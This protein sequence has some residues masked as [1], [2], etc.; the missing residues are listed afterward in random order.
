[1]P[2]PT[3]PRSAD[4]TASL[5][6]EVR[7]RM[8]ETFLDEAST[9]VVELE[10]A[11]LRLERGGDSSAVDG[12]FRAAHTIKGS[13]ASVGFLAV[14]AFVHEV[15]FALE[16]LR[17]GRAELTPV[18]LEALLV[19]VDAAGTLLDA[20]AIGAEAPDVSEALTRLRRAF[21]GAN[22]MRTAVDHAAPKPVADAT[23]A[24]V[25]ALPAER[26]A[27]AAIALDDGLTL[28]HARF[29]LPPDAFER[30]LDPLVL[31]LALAEEGVMIHSEALL[32]GLP[33]LAALDPMRCHLGF[34]VL[35]ATADTEEARAALEFVPADAEVVIDVLDADAWHTLT[36]PAAAA[37]T[38]PT[39]RGDEPRAATVRGLRVRQERVDG[40]IEL[41]GELVTARN[42]LLH[43]QRQV[44]EG[45]DGAEVARRLK[46]TSGAINRMVGQ[47]QSDVLGLRMVPMRTAME[48]LPRVIRDVAA[49]R[50][51]L[52]ALAVIGDDTEV[53]RAVAD[54][55]ADPLVHLVRNAI[56]HGV[57]S[58]QARLAAGKAPE[59]RVTVTARREAHGVVVEVRDDGDGIDAARVRA[60]AVARGV[61]DQA[62]ADR[63]S[64]AESLA[65]V[66]AAGLSTATEVSDISGRG[67]GMDAVRS[68]VERMGGTV[69]VA[70]V[71]GEGTSVRIELP[72]TLSIVRAL[73]VRVGVQAFAIPLEAV[74]ETALLARD[75]RASLMGRPA[76]LSDGAVTAVVPLGEALR[77][78][79]SSPLQEG[80]WHAVVVQS[81]GTRIAFVVDALDP[82]QE[83]MVK[84]LAGS[85][86]AGGAIAG[87]SVMG[88]GRVALV[89][90]PAG[91]A[92]LAADWTAGS[93]RVA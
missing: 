60:A 47:L 91:L 80:E 85:L 9:L 25:A 17:A 70:S 22:G 20:A 19:S 23:R 89:L 48:R 6:P 59:A 61:V 28:V 78:P 41:V 88:D 7:A 66:F 3:P 33:A 90:D 58:P 82:P 37:A 67:V 74:R 14:A 27:A 73:F 24:L 18:A 46:T 63:M 72:T 10:E 43:L 45:L 39:R 29:R 76:T 65:L 36:V 16:A 52:V 92:A 30:G 55:I 77:L 57:E 1:M 38:A 13:A 93:R 12:A 69:A 4:P 51:K 64:E 62:T 15:E 42:A 26:R 50:E 75:D 68:S 86:T 21:G 2:A 87:A 54:A 5:P 83:I 53:D 71:R 31:L 49:Q 84:P 40:L 44:D 81:A 8:R 11:L 35:L 56:D 79:A 32:D 34:A